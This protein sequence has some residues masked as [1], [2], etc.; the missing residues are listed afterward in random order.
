MPWRRPPR[1][2]K[3][4]LPGARRY[5][6]YLIARKLCIIW[7][8]GGQSGH[9]RLGRKA[10]RKAHKLASD[11]FCKYLTNSRGLH[12]PH[13]HDPLALIMNMHWGIE[14]VCL[15]AHEMGLTCIL[16]SNTIYLLC[17][18]RGTRLFASSER[19]FNRTAIIPGLALWPLQLLR[20]IIDQLL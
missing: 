10:K 8:R 19:L 4:A 17:F 12:V 7:T 9:F 16:V 13:S 15:F 11:Y 3:G 14:I 18:P 20:L 5:V 2:V 1:R 6:H